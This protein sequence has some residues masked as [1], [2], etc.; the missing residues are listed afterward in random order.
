MA[1]YG[2]TKK[3]ATR[4]TKGRRRTI[5]YNPYTITDLTNDKYEHF[6]SPSAK[7]VG[8][9]DERHDHSKW[10]KR[11]TVKKTTER[12]INA[13][14]KVATAVSRLINPRYKT[15]TVYKDGELKKKVKRGMGGGRK[16]KRY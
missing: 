2:R 13:N 1:K 10:R 5:E 4:T 14:S 3:A 15:K 7:G 6:A 16:V 11:R 9:I 8:R 12:T